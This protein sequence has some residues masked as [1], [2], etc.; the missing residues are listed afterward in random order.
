MVYKKRRYSLD[1]KNE[2]MMYSF[3]SI[4]ETQAVVRTNIVPLNVFQEI[5]LYLQSHLAS[6]TARFHARKSCREYL[7]QLTILQNPEA[8]PMM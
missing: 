7:V 8:F 6:R 2:Y 3:V 4:L 5:R 1:P